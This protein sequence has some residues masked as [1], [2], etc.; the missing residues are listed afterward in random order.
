MVGV[1]C[2]HLL[3]AGLPQ[4]YRRRPH[5]HGQRKAQQYSRAIYSVEVLNAQRV[6]FPTRGDLCQARYDDLISHLR[7]KPAAGGLQEQDLEQIN[8]LLAHNSSG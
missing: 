2:H 8:Q 1:V 7:P 5:P 3:H 4:Q 6:R